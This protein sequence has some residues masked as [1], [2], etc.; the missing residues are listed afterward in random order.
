M[1]HADEDGPYLSTAQLTQS[2]EPPENAERWVAWAHEDGSDKAPAVEVR[3]ATLTW[4]LDVAGGPAHR[5]EIAV[6]VVDPITGGDRE[7]PCGLQPW[8]RKPPAWV[9]ALVERTGRLSG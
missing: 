8:E 9:V 7:I 3:S 5:V 6:T 2:W 4:S 1:E